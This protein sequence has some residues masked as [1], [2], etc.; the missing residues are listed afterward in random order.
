M[1]S[2]M[3][4]ATCFQ[5]N[6]FKSNVEMVETETLRTQGSKN[7]ATPAAIWGA[8][9]TKIQGRLADRVT[10]RRSCALVLWCHE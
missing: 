7:T 6:T 3:F 2:A 5:S 9:L 10:H 1:S 8:K 4:L